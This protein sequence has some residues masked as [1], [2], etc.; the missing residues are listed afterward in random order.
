MPVRIPQNNQRWRKGWV[1]KTTLWSLSVLDAGFRSQYD[2][3]LY[4]LSFKD[5]VTH[6]IS[7][8]FYNGE[9]FATYTRIEGVTYMGFLS[10]EQH[11]NSAFLPYV[12][13]ALLASTN[14]MFFIQAIRQD[15]S[16]SSGCRQWLLDVEFE[17]A[18]ELNYAAIQA[19]K[20]TI[21]FDCA[22]FRDPTIE[23]LRQHLNTDADGECEYQYGP[24]NLV[25]RGK[26]FDLLETAHAKRVVQ[27]N[28]A[29]E[30]WRTT[31]AD[32]EALF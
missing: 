1:V 22:P 5:N 9:V 24:V 30:V 28:L 3:V 8:L 14:E 26:I 2:A 20:A 31:G 13:K 11:K 18:N 15:K 23:A 10:E 12:K 6:L 17:H 16:S 19:K 7:H 4:M 32:G 29:E 21:S 27:G 25:R